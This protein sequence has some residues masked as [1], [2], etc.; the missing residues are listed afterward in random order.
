MSDREPEANQ[1]VA[2]PPPAT[3]PLPAAPQAARRQQGGCVGRFFAALLV[4]IITTVLALVAGA[5][6]LLYLGFTPDTARR[7]ADAQAQLETLQSQNSALQTEVAAQGQRGSTDHEI[8]SEI[9]RQVQD[10]TQL[11]DQLR[12]EREAS[13]SQNATLVAEAKSSRDAVAVFATAEA[14][15]AALLQQLEQRSARVE[16]FLQRLSDIADDAAID[17]GAAPVPTPAS[18]PTTIVELSPT[19]TPS[20]PPLPPT[21]TPSPATA[22]SSTAAPRATTA[23]AAVTST[24]APTRTPLAQA[25]P[26]AGR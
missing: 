18:A 23:T 15:R 14:G 21:P 9:G 16:R 4:V 13:V 26:T 8:L 25:S 12:A 1:A 22:P 11:R 6:G 17:L 2:T 5:A 19:L 3:G 20:P 24:A 10:I 7:L